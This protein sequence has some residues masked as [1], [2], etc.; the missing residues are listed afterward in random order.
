MF[1]RVGFDAMSAVWYQKAHFE[2]PD[3]VHNVFI[4]KCNMVLAH[5]RDEVEKMAAVTDSPQLLNLCEIENE[6]LGA[7][8]TAAPDRCI[9]RF[10]KK[11]SQYYRKVH[12]R[13]KT[14]AYVTTLKSMQVT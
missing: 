2:I 1:E 7:A 12:A 13:I 3:S 9:V 14:A 5:Y 6:F 10:V 8:L 4:P 11:R